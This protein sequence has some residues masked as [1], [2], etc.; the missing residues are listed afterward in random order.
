MLS[1]IHI[2][3]C[4]RTI[5]NHWFDTTVLRTNNLSQR[6]ILDTLITPPVVLSVP[7]ALLSSPLQ[8][9]QSTPRQV[10]IILTVSRFSTSSY[11]W[12]SSYSI[13]SFIFVYDKSHLGTCF[14]FYYF[15]FLGEVVG[16][17]TQQHDVTGKGETLCNYI[18]NRL[19]FTR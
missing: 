18:N 15:H 8:H 7:S 3:Q 13:F 10:R 19:E 4:I 17:D 1:L 2:C 16:V 12:Y 6:R 11:S 14:L 5:R 9:L